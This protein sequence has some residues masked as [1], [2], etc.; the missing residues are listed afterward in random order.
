MSLASGH[1][2]GAHMFHERPTPTAGWSGSVPNTGTFPIWLRHRRV[3]LLLVGNLSYLSQ[4]LAANGTLT[5]YHSVLLATNCP[6][7]QITKLA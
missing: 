6:M 2:R 5:K 7:V 4:V 1:A 3:R